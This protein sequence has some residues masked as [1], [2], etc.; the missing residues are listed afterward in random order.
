MNVVLTWAACAVL[1][2]EKWNYIIW[3]HWS[4]IALCDHELNIVSNETQWSN[5]LEVF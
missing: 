2:G 3:L 4:F 5:L 1:T